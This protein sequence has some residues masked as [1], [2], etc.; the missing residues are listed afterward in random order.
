MSLPTPILLSQPQNATQF[1]SEQAHESVRRNSFK[2]SDFIQN[3]LS[4]K[5]SGINIFK[6]LHQR[7]ALN[8]PTFDSFLENP[9]LNRSPNVLCLDRSRVILS[10]KYGNGNYCHASY[11]D[12]YERK[13]GY[14]FSQAPFSEETE[15]L[16]WRMVID[17][18]PKMIIVLACITFQVGNEQMMRCFW[19][20]EG[21]KVYSNTIRVCLVR[22]QRV[23][24]VEAKFETRNSNGTTVLVCPNGATRCGTYAAVDVILSRIVNEKKV[25]AKAAI[26]IILSQRYGCFQLIEHYRNIHNI[27]LK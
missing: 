10:T 25:G 4:K 9:T 3:L 17:V 26:E 2:P 23:K 21:E 15:E 8:P 1:S 19:S 16:F 20:C 14:V 24:E 18:D 6:E 27:A 12:S 11:V 7:I 13:D 5:K 22:V